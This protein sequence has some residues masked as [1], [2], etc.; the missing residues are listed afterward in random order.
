L[1]ISLMSLDLQ[2]YYHL[3]TNAATPGNHLFTEPS[4]GRTTVRATTLKYVK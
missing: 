2:Q 1:L 4:L 3:T